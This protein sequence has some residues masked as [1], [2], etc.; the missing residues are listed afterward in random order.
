MRLAI[1]TPFE[2][3][4]WALDGWLSAL[5]S[6]VRPEGTTFLWLCNSADDDF[7]LRLEEAAR[8]LPVT[9]WRD[10]ERIAEATAMITKDS[11]VARLW[12]EMRSRLPA[13][14]THVL[15]LEDDVISSPSMITDL[16]ALCLDEMVV[17]A[18][19]VPVRG[20]TIRASSPMGPFP[21]EANW[22]SFGC[23]LF[24]RPLFDAITLR[25]GKGQPLPFRGY[26]NWVGD[27]IRA[28]GG[29]VIIAMNMPVEHLAQPGMAA[30]KRKRE[31][32]R[33]ASYAYRAWRG[34]R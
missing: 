8:T 32:N 2:G 1:L 12:R 24:P 31:R 19:P 9:L 26:D 20:L 18:A 13:D 22:S 3:K 7:C 21:S 17:V 15:C 10:T 29:K 25:S 34:A 6:A 28:L 14:L 11:T 16:L 4:G 5:R 27:E 33:T 30:P 23:T